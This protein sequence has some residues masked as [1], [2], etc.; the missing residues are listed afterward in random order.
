MIKIEFIIGIIRI[1]GA[2]TTLEMMGIEVYIIIE[3]IEE[4]LRR[5]TGHMTEVEAGIETIEE[6]L[7]GIEGDSGSRNTG[8]LMSRDIREERKC[9]YCSEPG[10][11]IWK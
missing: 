5:E 8:W 11:F 7:V 9:H 4:I 1:S 10:H 2:G 3:V 6:D